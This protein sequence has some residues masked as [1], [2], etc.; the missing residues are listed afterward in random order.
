MMSE[1]KFTQ[2]TWRVNMISNMVMDSHGK[3][4]AVLTPYYEPREG[5]L[6]N[7]QEQAFNAHLIAA[8]P[9]LYAALE[10]ISADYQGNSR[11]ITRETLEKGLKALAKARGQ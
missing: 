2:G 9:D 11:T 4:I 3:A 1:T 6:D 7:E 5:Y 10:S 8:A